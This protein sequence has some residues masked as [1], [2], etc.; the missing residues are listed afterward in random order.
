MGEP[1][2]V[3]LQK[4]WE[5]VILVWLDETDP[6]KVRLSLHEIAPGSVIIEKFEPRLLEMTQVHDS[7]A[8]WVSGPYLVQLTNGDANWRRLVNGNTLVWEAGGVTYR[9][10]SA[11]SL[12]DAIRIAESI[13]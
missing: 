9:L 1:D 5:M 8:A 4:S 7:P 6:E 3:F 13:E 2:R 12:E 11:L 10:E